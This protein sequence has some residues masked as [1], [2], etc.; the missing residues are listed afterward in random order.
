MKKVFFIFSLSVLML[1]GCASQAV[2][3]ETVDVH[4]NSGELQVEKI[5]MAEELERINPIAYG[6]FVDAVLYEQLGNPYQA[7]ESYRKALQYY[8]DSYLIRTSLAQNLYRM[9]RFEDALTILQPVDPADAEV[10]ALRG[11][12]YRASGQVDSALAAYEEAVKQDSTR[13]EVFS[14]LAS[15]YSREGDFQKA[16]WAF[17]HLARLDPNNYAIWYELGRIH[18][19]LGQVDSALVS[20]R[21]STD[22]RSDAVNV[23]S[24]IGLG[25]IYEAREQLD[26]ALIA[27]EGALA[28]DSANVVA[29]RNL[30]GVYVKLDSL[31]QAAYHA[32]IESELAP[33]DRHSSRRLGMLYFY[34]DSLEQAD[35]VFTWLVDSGERNP[36]NHQYLGRIAMRQEKPEKAIDEFRQV[37]EIAD[38]TW[39]PWADLALAYRAAEKPGKEIEAYRSGI[40]QVADTASQARLM[41]ALGS[42]YEQ[43][44]QFDSAVA[45]FEQLVELAPNYD[46]ALNY[47][48]YMLADSGQRLDYARELIERAL[49]I[50]P[51]NAAYLD[52]YGW[53]LYR[54]G[55]YKEAREQLERAVEHDDD[56]V[57]FDHLGDIYQA[58][59]K[60]KEAQHWWQ[61]ALELDPH[62]AAIRAKLEQ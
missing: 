5:P 40:E 45:V 17:Q 34:V 31:E 46:A 38:S 23:M 61:K 7:T 29:H 21:K 14:F 51:D 37:V 33:L 44:G 32:R 13:F 4:T 47:L 60:A 20:F 62:N 12:M 59:G 41:M 39:E 19:R 18:L 42:T 15:A 52:S 3:R 10:W 49:E 2:R 53:V 57:M 36:I 54:L 27:F 22:I 43:A 9:Q 1:T 24:Y 50:D 28:A 26:S 25:E 16:K 56:P 35:S 55:K 30:A 48:G 11:D 8:P 58:L 6:F